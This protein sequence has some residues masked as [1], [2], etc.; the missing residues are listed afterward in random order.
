MNELDYR[1]IGAIIFI[2][3]VIQIGTTLFVIY[4]KLPEIENHLK[5]CPMVNSN[6]QHWSGFGV[7]ARTQRLIYIT[8]IFDFTKFRHNTDCLDMNEVKS[9]PKNLKRW[10]L[11]PHYFSYFLCLALGIYLAWEKWFLPA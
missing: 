1:W 11:I 8:L 5:N 7:T 2:L 10:L 9:L 4:F 3:F 6:K